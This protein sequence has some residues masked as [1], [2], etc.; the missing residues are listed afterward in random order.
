[1]SAA[2]PL[3]WRDL[4]DP[5]RHVLGA[6][7]R[8]VTPRDSFQLHAMSRVLDERH[9]EDRKKVVAAAVRRLAGAGLARVEQTRT[10]YSA[11]VTVKGTKIWRGDVVDAAPAPDT[12]A[13]LPFLEGVSA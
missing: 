10:S 5:E 1:M 4:S 12:A 13:G 7:A 6:L 3:A 8:A 9:T 11:V 2:A